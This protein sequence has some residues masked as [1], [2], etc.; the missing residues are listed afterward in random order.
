MSSAI[1]GLLPPRYPVAAARTVPSD[2]L[3]AEEPFEDRAAAFG[4]LLPQPHARFVQPDGGPLDPLEDAVLLVR[5]LGRRVGILARLLRGL[6]AGP[7]ACGSMLLLSR[8]RLV[9]S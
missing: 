4:A 3:S 5:E 8:N 7:Y 2:A 9:G 6:R 1:I